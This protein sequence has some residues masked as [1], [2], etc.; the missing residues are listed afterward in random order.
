MQAE[1]G[2]GQSTHPMAARSGA[3]A[4]SSTIELAF[5]L[6]LLLGIVFASI[7]FGVALY[8]QAVITNASREA[9]RLGVAFRVPAPSN[10]EIA[11]VATSYCQHNLVTFG[12][13]VTPQVNVTTTTSR[14]PGDP[15][16]VTIT[17]AYK[18]IASLN[19]GS[20]GTLSARTTMTFE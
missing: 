9:A 17:Y 6:P 8:N 5:I 12:Q 13:A 20:P 16:T 15:L 3:Q 7:N 19:F 14:L 18:G 11:A 2:Q 10:A 4:G 1:S